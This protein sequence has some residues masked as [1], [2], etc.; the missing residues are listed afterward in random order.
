MNEFN[1]EF[2][3]GKKSSVGNSGKGTQ[4][5]DKHLVDLKYPPLAKQIMAQADLDTKIMNFII[6]D[7]L[8]LNEVEREGFVEFMG[9]L[10]G[11]LVVKKDVFLLRDLKENTQ[12]Q[13]LT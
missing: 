2:A 5:L 1:V 4:N 8:S 3:A 11:K 6:K 13:K 10:I 12:T 9:G 7:T